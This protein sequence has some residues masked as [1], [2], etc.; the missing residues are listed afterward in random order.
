MDIAQQVVQLVNQQIQI[1]QPENNDVDQTVKW[2]DLLLLGSQSAGN[3]VDNPLMI[4][5][6]P[7]QVPTSGSIPA[8]F[9]AYLPNGL[10]A[11]DADATCRFDCY[12]YYSDTP[13]N[14]IP[15]I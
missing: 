8:V 1:S 7:L 3:F 2:L 5:P 6:I 14:I 9:T 10:G 12:F 4:F 11:S 15:T 13:R